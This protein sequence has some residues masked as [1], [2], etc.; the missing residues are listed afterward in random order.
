MRLWQ[1]FVDAAY[2]SDREEAYLALYQAV[3]ELPPA[4]KDTLAYVILHLQRYVCISSSSLSWQIHCCFCY[5]AV[6]KWAEMLICC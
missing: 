3:S 4:N 5:K 2:V 6:V 1:S